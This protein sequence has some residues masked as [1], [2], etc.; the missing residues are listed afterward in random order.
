MLTEQAGE[1]NQLLMAETLHS[2]LFPR[3]KDCKFST[4]A[5][6][7]YNPVEFAK[8]HSTATEP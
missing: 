5:Y 1:G 8:E 3:G 4:Y 7:K 2:M 6:G